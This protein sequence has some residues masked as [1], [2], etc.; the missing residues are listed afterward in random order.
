[1]LNCFVV[2]FHWNRI[3]FL[4]DYNKIII[5]QIPVRFST[6]SNVLP[7]TAAMAFLRLPLLFIDVYLFRL[8]QIG[9]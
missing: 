5:A 4:R 2:D 3:F 9:L 8:A 1:M 6:A 7:F